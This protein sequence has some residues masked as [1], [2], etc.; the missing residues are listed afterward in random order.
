MNTIRILN[1]VRAVVLGLMIE[2][3]PVL[4][5]EWTQF[6][7][8]DGLGLTSAARL[9]LTWS[10]TENVAWKT[11]IA[12]RG[13]SSPVVVGARLWMT[14]SR[15]TP[16][17]GEA[18]EAA[19]QEQLKGNPLAKQMSLVGSVELSAV[20]V[21]AV[22][23]KLLQDVL[24][25]SIPRPPAIH[26]LNSY[27]SPTP[28][29]D[30]VRIVCH[31]GELGTAC[32]EA[33]TGKIAWKTAFPSAHAVGAGSSPLICD[34][35]VIIPC[36]GTDQQYVV[37]LKVATGELAWK[38]KRPPMTG[39]NGDFHK[40]YSSPVR[41]AA[42]QV[43]IPGAQWVVSY[44]PTSGKEVWRVR[45]GE[46]FSNVPAPVVSG[47][48]VFVCTGYM[49]PHLIAIRSDGSGDVTSSHVAWRISKS[50]PTMPSPVVVDDLL[51][52]VTDQ[53]VLTCATTQGDVVWT[54][55][56]GG[57]YSASPLATRDRIYFCSRDGKTTVI[58]PG[59]EYHELAVNT[60]E[61]QLM[62]SPAVFDD[63][64]ILRTD[65]HL[66]RIGASAAAR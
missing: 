31:F 32:L 41:I 61:G 6:R 5:G 55:R 51:Y 64:L 38:T 4:A 49:Q 59:R 27:A 60:L 21:D 29:T 56:L 40:S 46:G 9:P 13:W 34:G 22:T 20:C 8:A 28:A 25:F 14:T 17:S 33:D 30:G 19:R 66:Y 54:H 15:E 52:F 24:L 44:E 26:S 62:A 18:L 42:D 23:G 45:H 11:A 43:V 16:L 36:D 65:T 10:E 53:G 37:G 12:G 3:A 58:R 1:G 35:T 2:A 7:G 48:Q 47:K 39:T 63:A 57:N 50:V